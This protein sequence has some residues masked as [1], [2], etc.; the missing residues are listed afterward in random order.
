MMNATIEQYASRSEWLAARRSGIGSSDAAAILGES[1]W[2]SP[3]SIWA[4]K[5]HELENAD[6]SERMR[7]GTVLEA[8]IRDEY[9]ART[10]RKVRHYGAHS[11]CR[12][13]KFDWLMASLDGEI[14]DERPGVYEGKIADKF[15]AH[16]WADEP[17]LKYQIQI[18]HA[19]M[20]TGHRWGSLAVLIG[21]NEFKYF[22]VAAND[23]FQMALIDRLAKFWECVRT[24][25]PPDADGSEATKRALKALHPL[26]SGESIELP[27]SAGTLWLER[28][29]LAEQIKEFE[30]RKDA[31]DNQFK[32]WI[33][34]NT[35]GT[36]E[37]DCWTY[38]TQSRAEHQVKA[39]TF[40]VL[41]KKGGK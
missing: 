31:I 23:D 10:G 21:G 3:Y 25:T 12:N 22:D 37:G 36:F 34:P 8:P 32:V 6:E 40:R 5:R 38:K 33:G 13:D 16:D 11:I 39:S 14:V 41:K 17:P 4:E 15:L 35:Y 2:A 26:D 28:Q 7:W 24:G 18:Q 30:G 1:S 27:E 19:M 29:M 9:A 20:V